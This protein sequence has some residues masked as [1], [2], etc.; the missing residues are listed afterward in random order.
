MQL[1]NKILNSD[2]Q[3]NDVKKIINLRKKIFNS[4]N[5]IFSKILKKIR[6]IKHNKICYKNSAF[7]SLGNP[8]FI[9]EESVCFPHGLCGV[10]ISG[11]AIIG[12]N[13]TIFQQV[14]IGSNTLED[15]KHVGAPTIGDNVFIGAG[16][17]IIGNVKIGDNVRIGA[18]A[19]VVDDVPNNSTIIMKG[20][21][22]IKSSKD[23]KNS[24]IELDKFI[25]K[26]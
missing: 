2:Y 6:E 11:G 1:I 16:A 8:I 21:K 13:C 25:K 9:D 7:I 12:K 23:R 4:K 15:S 22:I 5:D 3:I 17:K 18:G 20:S 10:F 19:I 24:F 14:T 26:K